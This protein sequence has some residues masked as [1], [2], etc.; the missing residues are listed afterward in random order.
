MTE[1]HYPDRETPA[2][3][4]R[5]CI[6]P[7]VWWVRMPLPF[8]LDHINL[9]L[10][11][12]ADDYTIVDTGLASNLVRDIW[13]H[14]LKELDKPVG[15]IVVTHFH[16]DHLGL[17]GWLQ[18][19]TG[20]PVFM[21]S[22]EFLTSHLIWD[23]QAGHGIPDMLAFF[24]LH[25]LD[26][27]RCKALDERGNAYRKGVP[28]LPREYHRLHHGDTLP[29]PGQRWVVREGRG[30]S[31]EH[32]ALHNADTGVLISGDMLLP[33]ITTNI[34]V[35]AV[36]PDAD[37]LQW[38]LDSLDPWRALPDDT[39]VLPSH[40][41]PFTGARG[42]IDVIEAHHAERLETLLAACAQPATACDVLPA[43]FPRE[44]D[45]H[46]TMFAMGEA[47]A[48]LNRLV[49]TGRLERLPP[50]EGVIRF[51]RTHHPQ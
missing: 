26:E 10:I 13:T 9:W 51:R 39:L 18:E 32:V 20:A 17:A 45:A 4:Q 29:I 48:H 31:P 21:S 36:T 16:P 49:E 7:G 8:A 47:I 33:R 40:G 43:L 50:A 2:P 38:Y 15:R 11:E 1:P 22:G 46:Q 27:A 6:A 37:S 44:L 41:L 5:K 34:T 35:F 23:Q 3:G 25:G 42:R 28:V 30:H 24:R 12:S 14:L 19:R